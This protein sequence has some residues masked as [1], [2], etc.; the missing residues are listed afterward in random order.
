MAA[1]ASRESGP[2]MRGYNPTLS[3]TIFV[4]EMTRSRPSASMSP[5]SAFGKRKS[6]TLRPRRGRKAAH[7]YPYGY[8]ILAGRVVASIWCLRSSMHALYS[9][10]GKQRHDRVT[11]NLSPG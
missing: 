7:R 10:R 8:R 2:Q 9:A 4:L 5:M 1:R 11:Q 3:E 6:R